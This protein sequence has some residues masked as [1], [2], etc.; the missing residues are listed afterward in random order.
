MGVQ[1]VFLELFSPQ[2]LE[3]VLDDLSRKEFRE[4][5]IEKNIKDVDGAV[6]TR[7]QL[8][9]EE[10]LA[11]LTGALIREP[12]ATTRS[13][14]VGCPARVGRVRA[15]SLDKILA[16]SRVEFKNLVR[17]VNIDAG[18]RVI[19]TDAAVRARDL[20]IRFRIQVEA[21]EEM[22]NTIETPTKVKSDSAEYS[23]ND[24]F[25]RNPGNDEK[26][27]GPGSL[28]EGSQKGAP[29]SGVLAADTPS[30]SD[31]SIT[32]EFPNQ[33]NGEFSSSRR[34]A[35]HDPCGPTP[36]SI[37]LL[38]T[39]LVVGLG[40]FFAAKVLCRRRKRCTL[41]CYADEL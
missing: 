22:F 23:D 37:P 28:P 32:G 26:T 6:A 8:I 20:R 39:G 13:R 38:A 17:S 21:L 29:P 1:K 11:S 35:S 3:H 15:L 16:L 40:A 31:M 7:Y 4:L 25:L 27:S 19:N 9:L 5:C 2:E 41:P 36:S 34:L 14:G 18:R 33:G 10:E 12:T 30:D 24:S